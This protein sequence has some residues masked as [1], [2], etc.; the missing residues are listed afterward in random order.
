MEPTVLRMVTLV[1]FVM[2][3]RAE[4]PIVGRQAAEIVWDY[5]STTWA[6]VSHEHRAASIGL[7]TKSPC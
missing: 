4:S 3:L 7:V 6:D 2:Y 1:T 5:D